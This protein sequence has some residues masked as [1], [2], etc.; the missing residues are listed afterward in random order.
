M[1][2]NVLGGKLNLTQSLNQSINPFRHVFV[3]LGLIEPVKK[4]TAIQRWRAFTIIYKTL[5]TEQI[6]HVL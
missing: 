1:T 3:M 6:M 2:Y 4:C 5:Y